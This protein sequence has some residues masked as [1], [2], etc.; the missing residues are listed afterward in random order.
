MRLLLSRRPLAWN[1]PLIT[2]LALGVAVLIGLLLIWLPP[3]EG[4]AFVG[5][6]AVGLGTIIEPFVGLGAALLLGPLK[7]YLSAEVPQIPD[8]IAHAF[9]ALALASWSVR[10]LSRRDLRVGHSP[11]LLPLL[12]FLGAALLSLWDAIGL[13]SYGIPELIKWVEIVLLFIFVKEHLAGEANLLPSAGKPDRHASDRKARTGCGSRRLSW[14][15]IVLL[16]VGLFQAG[17]GIWQFGVRGEGPEHFAILGGD[18]FRAYGTFEQPNPYAGYLG[19]TAA[20]ALGVVVE[21]T[22]SR[23]VGWY[24]ARLGGGDAS[25]SLPMY[26]STSF[27]VYLFS[28][29]AAGAMLVSLGAS[30]SRGAWIGFAA[31]VLAMTVALPRSPGWGILLV[32]ALVIGGAA[33][34]ASGRL[35]VSFT[36]RLTSFVQAT[37][38]EDVRGVPINDANY[39]V[40][41]RLAHWQAAVSMFRYDLWTGIGFG[42]YEAAYTIFA[43]INWPIALGHA[44]NYYLNLA[45]ETGL[46]GLVGYLV[47]WGIVF[48]QTWRVTRRARGFTRGL[49]IGLLGA[50]THLSVHHLLDNLYVNNVHLHI[51]VL[52][53]L[54]GFVIQQ[55]HQLGLTH[56][57]QA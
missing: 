6:L 31:A 33:L 44:H 52:L 12:G 53:G 35:P 51:G 37:R 18:F 9:I 15:L 32:G 39:A 7:A 10:R 22:R 3:L 1:G 17:V 56:E 55:T 4:T 13:I 57:R 25:T 28:G 49:G 36:A 27:P 20:L 41:E 34:Y 14:L 2:P 21:A 40:I 43:L 42:C 26:Q 8:Q 24:A 47:L 45:A 54:L 11:L 5:L 48:W 29:G 16:G 38:L 50:W 19:L 23:C 46:I 30:W